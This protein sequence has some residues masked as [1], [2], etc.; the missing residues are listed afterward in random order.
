M[1]APIRLLMQD[2]PSLVTVQPDETLQEAVVRMMEH[3]I[4]QLPVV[5]GERKPF[6]NPASFV[7]NTSI[8]RAVRVFGTTLEH[9]RVR[10][11]LVPARTLSVDEDL[12]SKMDDLLEAY[13]VLVLNP[14]RTIA[15]IVTSYD[16]TR[17][18][19]HRAEDMLLVEDVETTLK[20]H[21]RIAFGGDENDPGGPLQAAVNRLGSTMH[22]VRAECRKSFRRL[23][24]DN[25][26]E[27]TDTLVAEYVDSKFER[28]LRE[29]RFDKLTLYD[30]IELALQEEA[31]AVLAEPYNV[32]PAAF[33]TMLDG[34]R[35]TRNKLMH[36]DPGISPAERDQLRFCAAWFKNR[37]PVAAV[38]EAA[39]VSVRAAATVVGEPALESEGDTAGYVADSGGPGDVSSAD[40]RGAP[41][42]DRLGALLSS[43]PEEV[44]RV[45]ATFETVESM[46]GAPLPSAAREHRSWWAN[47][48][49][50]Q[51]HSEEWLNAGWRVAS[52]NMS[53]QRVIFAR[54]NERA[55]AFIRFFGEVQ[56]RLQEV[57]GFE[58]PAASPD[59]TSWLQLAAYRDVGCTLVVSFA[60][61][62]RMRLECYID[63]GDAAEN[64][65]I[66]AV[67]LERREWIEAEVGQPLA[68]EPLGGRRACRVALY[69]PGSIADEPE[70]LERLTDWAVRHAPQFHAALLQALP[71][72][73]TRD[74]S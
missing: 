4:S 41:A 49:A 25:Q 13:A 5:D 57:P 64:D 24:R 66:F 65:R 58:A 56:R 17:Y 28:S 59:G 35:G 29:R 34:V 6:G 73:G 52:I 38:N 70:A 12:F 11:A 23:C 32:Q 63:A 33:R 45:S 60:R 62:R 21:V 53:L 44:P 26:I 30:Y 8:V 3:E 42:Y 46:I 14:D 47:N 43:I 48:A 2:Q 68:W 22:S 36:F 1:A 9:L 39:E 51:Q 71:R 72:A 69:T 16:T 27:A 61:G 74:A 7:T 19:R 55:Q 20:E 37:P 67:L 50:I 31:W 10:D 18:F 15:G 54:S 40:N